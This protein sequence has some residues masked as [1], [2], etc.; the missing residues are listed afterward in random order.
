MGVLL[1]AFVFALNSF[2]KSDRLSDCYLEKFNLG[3]TERKRL[4]LLFLATIMEHYEKIVREKKTINY[5]CLELL[6]QRG[7]YKT[8]L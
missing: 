2:V 1:V 7:L 4:Y 8:A 5:D 6:I 3:D